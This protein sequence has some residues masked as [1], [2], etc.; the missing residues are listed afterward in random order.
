MKVQKMSSDDPVSTSGK[1]AFVQGAIPDV[2][3]QR[4]SSESTGVAKVPFAQ[5]SATSFST[6]GAFV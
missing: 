1:K 4:L 5:L 2:S 6:A 3:P